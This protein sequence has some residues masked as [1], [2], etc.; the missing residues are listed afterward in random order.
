MGP[1]L[2]K[3]AEIRRLLETLQPGIIVNAGLVGGLDEHDNL[4]V[5]DRLRL[6]SVIDADRRLTYPGG[7]GKDV[8]V[9]VDHPVFKPYEKYDLLLDYRARAC[10]MEAAHLIE[11][12]ALDLN[13]A[14]RLRI[15]LC[16]VCGDIPENYHLFKNEHLL[17]GWQRLSLREKIFL[18]LSFPGGPLR[19]KKLMELKFTAIDSL[20]RSIQGL[21]NRILD[22]RG[23]TDNLDSL[24]NPFIP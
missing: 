18:G 10:D 6:G 7:P 2:K 14:K 13:L 8:L 11:M 15:V 19:M 17:R 16:K 3:K 23:N 20:T 22:S 4:Q 21:M 9:T 1:A 12:A 5:G 24:F